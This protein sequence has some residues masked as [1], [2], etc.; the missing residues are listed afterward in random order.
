MNCRHVY[1]VISLFKR[2]EL[3]STVGAVT[4]PVKYECI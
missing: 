1:G 4:E 3:M 2:T